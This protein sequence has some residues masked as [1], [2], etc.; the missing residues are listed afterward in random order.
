MEAEPKP[1]S[2][3]G[4]RSDL[5]PP[6]YLA[7]PDS[8]YHTSTRTALHTDD[9]KPCDRP[10]C[11]KLRN[12]STPYD[13]IAHLICFVLFVVAAVLLFGIFGLSRNPIVLVSVSY[14]MNWTLTLANPGHAMG[15]GNIMARGSHGH[16][17]TVP[18]VFVPSMIWLLVL[19]LART[20]LGLLRELRDGLI[21]AAR[22][23]KC[24]IPEF[25]RARS[26]SVST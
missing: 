15:W 1:A 14:I 6:S 4:S 11:L 18:C 9:L 22:K 3:Y 26:F 13:K 16:W 12:A 17:T 10:D 19:W 20:V 21:F 7:L 8:L 25:K 23:A 24:A 5:L 2:R